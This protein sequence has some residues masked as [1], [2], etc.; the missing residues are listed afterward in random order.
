[1]ALI[2]L[3]SAAGTYRRFAAVQHLGRFHS[4]AGMSRLMKLGQS[5][6][7]DPQADMAGLS[8]RVE[9]ASDTSHRSIVFATP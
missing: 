7:N 9:V 6:E 2:R 3:I 4:E 1:M 8:R 5:V